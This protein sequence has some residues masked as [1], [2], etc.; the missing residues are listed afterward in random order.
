MISE[1]GVGVR[2]TGT[3]NTH[4]DPIPPPPLPNCNRSIGCIVLSL[5]CHFPLFSAF[6]FPTVFFSSVIFTSINPDTSYTISI[7][8]EKSR[9]T[10]RLHT[11]IVPAGLAQWIG[12]SDFLCLYRDR[13]YLSRGR[14]TPQ[15]VKYHV[16]QFQFGPATFI[17][18]RSRLNDSG[19]LGGKV[20]VG[21]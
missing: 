10:K 6:P 21:V 4:V 16:L 11:N 19:S 1:R 5:L 18:P 13:L 2:I 9:P 20:T 12:Q 17:K 14:H 8:T 15:Q 3:A 7:M